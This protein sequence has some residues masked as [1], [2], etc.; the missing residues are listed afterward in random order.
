VA[1]V[2]EAANRPCPNLS[3]I[4][5]VATALRSL[6]RTLGRFIAV[7]AG[8]GGDAAVAQLRQIVGDIADELIDE[9][10]VVRVTSVGRPRTV[11][12]SIAGRVR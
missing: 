11:P 3:L 8:G 2:F 10:V 5:Q 12:G 4:Y 1:A 7:V 9:F 6:N